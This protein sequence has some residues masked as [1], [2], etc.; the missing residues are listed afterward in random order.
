MATSEILKAYAGMK[1]LMSTRTTVFPLMSWNLY[2]FTKLSGSY[3]GKWPE[4]K[5]RLETPVMAEIK[6]F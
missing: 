1:R 4:V 5:R 2:I 6:N 3:F